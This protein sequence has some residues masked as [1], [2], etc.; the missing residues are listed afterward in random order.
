MDGDTIEQL[1]RRIIENLAAPEEVQ[2]D[3]GRVKNQSV[4]QMLQ[5]LSALERIQALQNTSGEQVKR[6]GLYKIRNLD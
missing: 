5:A 6:L 3:S 2:T 4:S 1:K